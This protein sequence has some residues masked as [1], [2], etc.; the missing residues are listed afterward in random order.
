MDTS[1]KSLVERVRLLA[2][3]IKSNE[4]DEAEAMLQDLQAD[5]PEPDDLVVFSVIIAVQRGRTREM[6][7][8]LEEQ[9]EDKFPELRA[10][11]LYML[12]EPTW[13]GVAMSLEDSDDPYVRRSMQQ[14]LGRPVEDEVTP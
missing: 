3:T 5:H 1:A 12:G 6:L 9:P 7:R 8:S 4:L 13:H 2:E 14:M 10:L 11:C